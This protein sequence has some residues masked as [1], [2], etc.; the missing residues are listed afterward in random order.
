MQ[1]HDFALITFAMAGFHAGV[2]GVI[3]T[4][5]ARSAAV[6][7]MCDGLRGCAQVPAWGVTRQPK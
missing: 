6:I 2:C 1:H 4:P 3:S 5:V 7:G